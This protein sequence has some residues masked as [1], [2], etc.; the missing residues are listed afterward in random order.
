MKGFLAVAR[1]EVRERRFVFAA[2]AFASVFPFVMPLFLGW[3]RGG[4]PEVRSL[5]ATVLGVGFVLAL[6]VGL[7]MS[8]LAPSMANRR[9]G[10]D[11]ARPVSSLALWYGHL[12]ATLLMAALAAVII[13]IPAWLAGARIPWSDILVEGRPPRPGMGLA[14][15]VLSDPRRRRPCGERDAA[16][17][18][19]AHRARRGSGSGGG[20][21][22]GREPLAFADLLRVRGPGARDLGIRARSRTRAS[23]RRLRLGRTGPDRHPGR[24]PGAFGHAL[25][26]DRDRA[27]RSDRL[28]ELGSRSGTPRPRERFLG[29]AGSGRKL[30]HSFRDGRAERRPHSSTTRRPAASSARRWSS[31]CARPSPA[32]ASTPRGSA[33]NPR[34]GRSRSFRCRSTVRMASR[35]RRGFFSRAIRRSSRS[36]PDGSRLATLGDGLLSIHDLAGSR[37]LASA[38]IDTARSS[39]RGF[40]DGNDRFRVYRQPDAGEG[41][42][43]LEILELDVPTK[44]LSR[45]GS[46][47]RDSG[48]LF[49]SWDGAGE[50]LITPSGG[51]VDRRPDR[52]RSRETRPPHSDV[53]RWNGLSRRRPD[54]PDRIVA[55]GPSAARLRTG[56]RPSDARFR[57]RRAAGPSS[58]AR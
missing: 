33:P 58:A 11:L 2:A 13:G 12:A 56:W 51:L 49:L 18:L 42:T 1:R 30:G 29:I 57:F 44:R 52:S 39:I 46:L 34:A 20:S 5:M 19:G 43:H 55:G 14:A 36:R 8:M 48:S 31:G 9:I 41:K 27:R 35:C 50:R 24:S 25:G 38:R 40:F 23:R 47:E 22:P 21:R 26:V 54:R 45:T 17:P 28:D 15:G 16:L 10:F 37:T 3:K 4:A 6:A 32:T 7:G 53:S